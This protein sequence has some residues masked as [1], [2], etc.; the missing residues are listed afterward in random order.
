MKEIVLDAGALIAL[1][2]GDREARAYVLLAEQGYATLTTSS[3]VVAQV[4]RGG[5]RQVR[6][7]RLLTSDLVTEIPLD[8]HE[9]R[10]IG[11]L[12]AAVGA[13]DVVDGHVAVIALERDA[14]VITSDPD[15]IARWGVDER[16]IVTC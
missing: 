3:A 12:A 11:A 14:I 9:S 4:W 1:E 7:S 8:A 15:D 13:W 10:R 2:R 16:R 5:A 6:L